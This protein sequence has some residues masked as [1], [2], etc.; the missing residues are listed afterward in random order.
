MDYFKTKYGVCY[1]KN[2]LYWKCD[3]SYNSWEE[4]KRNSNKKSGKTVRLV[5]VNNVW[6][7]FFKILIIEH[8]LSPRVDI[9]EYKSE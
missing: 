1:Q 3:C 2:P 5:R 6:P 9:E 7:K 8:Q 4:S